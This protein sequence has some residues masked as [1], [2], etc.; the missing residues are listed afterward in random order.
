TDVAGALR[1]DT[2]ERVKAEV[3]DYEA[4]TG[5]EVVVALVPTTGSKSASDY[6]RELFNRWGVGKRAANDGGLLLVAVQDRKLWITPAGGGRGDGHALPVVRLS[7]PG[8]AGADRVGQ[9]VGRPSGRRLP[10]RW[11]TWRGWRLRRRLVRRRRLGRWGRRR[12]VQRR[13]VRRRLIQ[14]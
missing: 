2:V 14:W 8:G 6:A 7:R 1:P 4:R 11:R 13:I 5:N 3:V 9:R 12:R 10:R